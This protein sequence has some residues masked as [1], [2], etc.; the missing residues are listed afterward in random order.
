MVWFPAAAPGS[1]ADHHP[2]AG[3]SAG[4]DHTVPVPPSPGA[5]AR[6]SHAQV[7]GAAEGGVCERGGE[8]GSPAPGHHREHHGCLPGTQAAILFSSTVQSF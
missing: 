1:P 7:L 3:P 2:G 4:V 8:R 5:E 6:H